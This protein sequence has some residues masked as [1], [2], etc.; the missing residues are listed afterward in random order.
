[1]IPALRMIAADRRGM[2]RYVRIIIRRYTPMMIGTGII[3]SVRDSMNHA[4]RTIVRERRTITCA[5]GII[6]ALFGSMMRSA[7]LTT[8]GSGMMC[9]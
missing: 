7:C 8:H 3:M 4:L 6:T 9:L 2:E 5:S 1:M